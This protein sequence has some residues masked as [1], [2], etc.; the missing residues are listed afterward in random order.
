LGC[1]NINS[2]AHG[3]FQGRAAALS[4][5]AALLTGHGVVVTAEG[6]DNLGVHVRMLLSFPL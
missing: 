1:I 2:P 6:R 3:L 4:F 5:A